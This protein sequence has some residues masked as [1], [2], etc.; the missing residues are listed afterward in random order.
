MVTARVVVI[1]RKKTKGRTA[2]VFRLAEYAA[3]VVPANL[4]QDPFAFR[5]APFVP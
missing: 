4:A 5:P 1:A 2:D 3:G